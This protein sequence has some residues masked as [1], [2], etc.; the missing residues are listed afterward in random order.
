MGFC[1]SV[2][3]N[4]N[5]LPQ[6]KQYKNVSSESVGFILYDRRPNETESAYTG[7]YMY[8]EIML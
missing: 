4:V 8:Y 5:A 2:P 1:I 3:S 6:Y 7:D